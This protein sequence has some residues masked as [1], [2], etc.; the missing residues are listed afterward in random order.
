MP[1]RYTTPCPIIIEKL[2][3]SEGWQD[4]GAG[5]RL[6]P[7]N[8]VEFSVVSE[9]ELNRAMLLARRD[10]KRKHLKEQVKLHQ[11]KREESRPAAGRNSSRALLSTECQL[12]DYSQM[13]TMGSGAKVFLYAPTQVKSDLSLSDSPPTR[14]PGLGPPTQVPRK[15]EDQSSLEVRRLQK[16]LQKYIQ[17][18]EQLA[19]KERSETVLDPDEEH[20]IRVRRQEQ[21]V[22][23]ARM[24]YVLQQQVKE[25][26]EDLEKLSPHKIKHTKKSRAMARLAAAHRGAVRALQTF[27]TH[28]ADQPEQ[29]P[30]LGHCRELGNLVRQLSLCSA[31]LEMDSCMPDIIMDLLLQIEDLDCLL[32]QKTSKRGPKWLSPSQADL[33]KGPA[34]LPRREKKTSASELRKPPVARKLLPDPLVEPDE[35]LVP[36]RRSGS[37]CTRGREGPSPLDRSAAAQARSKAVARTQPTKQGA[38]LESG[39]LQKRGVQ[40]STRPQGSGQPHRTKVAQ[41]LVKQARFQEPTIAFQL[42][43]MKP[44]VRESQSPWV[45]PGLTSPLA[46]P[47]RHT[48]K[49]CRS[50]NPSQGQE[51]LGEGAPGTM[52]KEV[53]RAEGTSPTQR[54][55]KSRQAVQEFLEPLL[56]KAQA[57][58]SLKPLLDNSQ[59][60]QDAGKTADGLNCDENAEFEAV[61][62][63]SSSDLELMLQRMEEIERSQEAVH[64]RYTQVAYSDPEF[65]TRDK[66]KGRECAV[67]GQ[68]LALPPPIQIKKLDSLKELQVDIVLERPLD[69]N[70]VEGDMETVEEPRPGT[71][72]PSTWHLRPQKWAGTFLSVP[73]NMLQSICDYQACYMQHLKGI[74]HEAVENFNPWLIAESL[75]E[76]LTE[77]AVQ[78][79][80]AEL[81]GLCEDYAETV[82]TAEFL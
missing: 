10:V 15:E 2:P 60:P 22:R 18:I 82:F 39:P 79:V 28:C 65:W 62:V 7:S 58:L 68:E 6:G 80:A 45:P 51:A 66:R 14:D 24:L 29:Q 48:E 67:G 37:S 70:A 21:A 47:Q 41:P 59:E 35:I 12:D 50:R 13:E 72:L 11:L 76:Q 3:Q 30:A 4:Q 61:P 46:L 5:S 31:R 8:S 1:A 40:L 17:K 52:K 33:V 54:L 42:K 75:A 19:R 49:G 25:I 26:Q 64:R 57:N 55:E 44:P 73:K 34:R 38:G 43:E 78:D 63:L 71:P 27:V 56:A 69:T 77:E 20:R 36:Q 23:S 32:A 81:H 74:S 9:E 53:L 16:E